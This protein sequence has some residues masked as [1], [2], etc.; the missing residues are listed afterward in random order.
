MI[1]CVCTFK[2]ENPPAFMAHARAAS[3]IDGSRHQPEHLPGA[4]Q[5]QHMLNNPSPLPIAAHIR[6]LATAD[7]L[8]AG[9]KA[10]EAGLDDGDAIVAFVE[11]R[12]E[13]DRRMWQSYTPEKEEALLQLRQRRPSTHDRFLEQTDPN[14]I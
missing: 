1:R 4:E 2:A 3:A 8:D 14:A 9:S 13:L 10:L 6:T 12:L 11:S 7:L 5:Y